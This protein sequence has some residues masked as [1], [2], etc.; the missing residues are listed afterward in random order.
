MKDGAEPVLVVPEILMTLEADDQE[1][2]EGTGLQDVV[3][4]TGLGQLDVPMVK[5]GKLCEVSGKPYL[6]GIRNSLQ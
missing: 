1:E 3:N 2:Q 5:V 6:S 4:I